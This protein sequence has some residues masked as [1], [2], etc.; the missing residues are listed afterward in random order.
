MFFQ[1][2]LHRWRPR[3]RCAGRDP[4]QIRQLPAAFA[5]VIRSNC[6]PVIARLPQAWKNP[7]YRRA[8]R[9]GQP[10]WHAIA[11]LPGAEGSNTCTGPRP[12]RTAAVSARM[13][14]L[15][16]VAMTGPPISGGAS[17]RWDR[18]RMIVDP[19][20]RMSACVIF[21]NL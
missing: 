17:E 15:V 1:R 12:A 20:G 10:P 5:L 6:A 19:T 9:L 7:T 18:G 3:R 14:G 13:S 11:Q 4:G 16:L 2:D 8:R 21:G